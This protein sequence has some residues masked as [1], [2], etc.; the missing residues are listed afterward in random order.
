MSKASREFLE[1]NLGV[2]TFAKD[3]NGKN[4]Y[5]PSFETWVN[6]SED[7]FVKENKDI[8]LKNGTNNE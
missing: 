1:K 8:I 4:F 2:T 6:E 5:I 7:T 3:D